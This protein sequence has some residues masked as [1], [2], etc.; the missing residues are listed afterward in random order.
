VIKLIT[1][2]MIAAAVAVFS[3]SA[4]A[5]PVTWSFFETG[6]SCQFSGS[7]SLPPQ[8]FVFA[9][10]TLPGPTSSG[11]GFWQ[12]PGT[13]PPVY[14]GDS[15]LFRTTN[16]FGVSSGFVPSGEFF[17]RCEGGTNGICDFD[18]SWSDIEGHLVHLAIT[19]DTQTNNIGGAILGH[20]PF[21][22][23]GGLIATD[24][25][26]LGGCSIAQC[27]I[28]GFWQ[29]D[30]LPVFEPGSSGLLFSGILVTWVAWR[31]RPNARGKDYGQ[32]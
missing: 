27:E 16:G 2:A 26:N 13:T 30:L 32:G 15:F 6:I 4:R 21:G 22:L 17:P 7:C 9:T 19:L 1:L 3:A 11:S 29:S 8:P 23:N 24:N 28:T 5:A 14:T 12:G 20:A 31:Y 10:L 25:T 18:I